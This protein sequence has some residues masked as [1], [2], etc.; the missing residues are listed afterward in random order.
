MCGEVAGLERGRLA[1]DPG[2][3]IAGGT[4]ERKDKQENDRDDSC[5]MRIHVRSLLMEERAMC[6]LTSNLDG[7]GRRRADASEVRLPKCGRESHPH[8]G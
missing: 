8:A 6:R 7:L 2:K 4:A 3:T 5:E 1:R